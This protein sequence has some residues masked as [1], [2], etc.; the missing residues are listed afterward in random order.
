MR[1]ETLLKIL[2][3]LNKGGA[4]EII[5]RKIGE[6]VFWGYAWGT[7][8]EGYMRGGI[9]DRGD[10]VFF[11]MASGEFAGAIHRMGAGELHWYVRKKFRGRG[12]LVEPMKSV[13]LP[14]IF[15]ENDIPRQRCSVERKRNFSDASARLAERIG[16]RKAETTAEGTVYEVRR[17]E[18]PV[19]SP[20]A[21]STP[22]PSEWTKLRAEVQAATRRMRMVIDVL[23]VKHPNA[24]KSEKVD[25]ASWAVTDAADAVVDLIEDARYSFPEH[26][27]N[28]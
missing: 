4:S 9:Q 13:V 1:D 12:L 21:S 15:K 26:E 18:V 22:V 11:V 2:K 25:S 5:H 17:E 24:L 10:E 14:F 16:F 28:R 27:R 19:Y 20:P 6:N 7:G 8:K 3:R 23:R